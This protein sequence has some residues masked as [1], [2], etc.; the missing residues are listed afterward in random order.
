MLKAI[1]FGA[2]N[3]GRGFI[4]YLLAKSGYEVTFV[5]IAD[6]LVDD[7]NKYKEYSVIILSDVKTEEKV[8]NVKAINLKD[9]EAVKKAVL[10]ADLVTTSIGANNLKSTAGLLKEVLE[11][12]MRANDRPLDII[13]CENALFATNI[14]KETILEGAS[15]EFKKY[16]DEKVGFPNSAVDRIVPNTNAVKECPIDVLVEDFFEWDIEKNKVKVNSE[17]D[18]AEYT[19]NLEPYLE[20]KLFMLNGAHATVAYLGYLKKYEYIH[21]AIMDEKIR[22]TALSFHKECLKALNIKH[23]MEISSLEDYSKKVIKRFE[24]SYLQDVVSRVGR[25]PIRKLSNKDRLVSPLKLCIEYNL[26]Y[27]TIAK[28]I[29]AGLLFDAEDDPKAKEVQALIKAEGLRA[30]INKVCGIEDEK[31]I[32]LIIEN[33][34]QIKNN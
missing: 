13:A 33:Y 28:G 34:N 16:L 2:G 21:E 8:K 15:E 29:A 19:D 1:H 22:E 10:D 32:D 5:D 27:N 23:G 9:K 3:I 24:N 11:E 17:I 30:A 26:E 14:I 7:I 4:G 20:R 6:F 18:G 31:V 12:R 25:D